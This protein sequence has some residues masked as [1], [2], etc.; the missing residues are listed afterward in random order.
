MKLLRHAAI[1]A[2]ATI[3]LAG[4][5]AGW[6][7][8]VGYA[9]Q[10][11]DAPDAPPSLAFPLG[12]DALGRDA[13]ARLLYGSRVSLSLAP[14]AAALATLI[15][16]L[17]GVT[18][19]YLGGWVDTCLARVI[20]L[21]LSV[22]W[23]FLLLSVRAALPLNVPPFESVGITF[24]LLGL[25]GWAAPAHVLRVAAREIKSEDFMVQAKTRGCR[26]LRILAMHL[27][28]NMRPMLA[29]QFWTSIP[30][31]ILSEAIRLNIVTLD[32]GSLIERITRNFNYESCLL[33]LV[34]VDLDPSAQ[35]N[36]WLSSAANHPWNP[37]H[38]APQ[39]AW[40]AEIDDLMR[41]QSVEPSGVRRKT[42]FDRVQAIVVDQAPVLYL[43]DKDSL[44]AVSGALGNTAPGVLHPQ[45]L[46]N[47]ERPYFRDAR[48]SSH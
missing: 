47:V 41:A 27:L 10:F 32:F 39:T 4:L 14:A 7:A 35:M 22:P 42:L 18:A 30:I 46:W 29:A 5:G 44:S 1:V 21:F 26:R 28:P 34:N 20:D 40:E 3:Y 24:L 38:P 25:L 8:P 16:A 31:F 45:T 43:V 15:G 12:T 48:G 6:L 2:L 23:L 11:R 36:V 33:G 37:A 17:V 9:R 19:G 13:F